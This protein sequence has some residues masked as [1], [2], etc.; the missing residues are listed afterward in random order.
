[1]RVGNLCQVFRHFC[2]DDSSNLVAERG[3]DDT[4]RL[5]GGRDHKALIFAVR[6]PFFQAPCQ[7]LSKA[8]FFLAVKTSCSMAWR[9]TFAD[10]WT[11]PGRSELSS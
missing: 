10:S 8:L 7:R 9:D 2:H 5:R 4:K 6:E 1:M 11:R 3:P